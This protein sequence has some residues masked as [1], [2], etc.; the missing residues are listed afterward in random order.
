MLDGSEISTTYWIVTTQ[1]SDLV[2]KLNFAHL[3]E[4][5]N[6]T[7]VST[8]MLVFIFQHFEINFKMLLTLQIFPIDSSFS[9]MQLHFSFAIKL[10]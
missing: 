3:N 8:S 2:G 4:N 10:S 5:L 9:V 7:N 6:H 1:K